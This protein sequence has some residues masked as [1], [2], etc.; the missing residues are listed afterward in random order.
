MLQ[1]ENKL[2]MNYTVG[3]PCNATKHNMIF[4]SS[5]HWLTQNIDSQ[6]ILHSSPSRANYGVSIVRIL[7]KIDRVIT[8][9]HCI[10][11]SSV[12]MYLRPPIDDT[13]RKK[14][15]WPL[16]TEVKWMA[17]KSLGHCGNYNPWFQ[18]RPSCPFCPRALAWY[19]LVHLTN[20][21]IDLTRQICGAR[22]FH[23]ISEQ[24]G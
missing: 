5:L 2:Q 22:T 10:Q 17:Q 18:L 13:R 12:C 23:M 6:K 16:A 21:T 15:Y 7:E 8:A 4:F 3:G 19:W 11:F 1:H 24:R 9:P 14:S 20:V